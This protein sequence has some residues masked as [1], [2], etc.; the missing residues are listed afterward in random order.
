MPDTEIAPFEIKDSSETTFRFLLHYDGTHP[1]IEVEVTGFRITGESRRVR[2]TF[3]I[4]TGNPN[5]I[6]QSLHGFLN[7]YL[8][9]EYWETE[10]YFTPGVGSVP[11]VLNTGNDPII[12]FDIIHQQF[13]Y[14]F[15]NSYITHRIL[16]FNP[17]ETMEEL[18]GFVEDF[19]DTDRRINRLAAYSVLERQ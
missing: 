13:Y 15:R 5:G 16:L 10:G 8:L 19:S 7:G 11:C 6:L 4:Q 14:E 17:K 9:N 12:G 1:A 18:K 3:F 2:D